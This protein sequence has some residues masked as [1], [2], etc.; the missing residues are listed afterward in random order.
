MKKTLGMIKAVNKFLFSPQVSWLSC[1][2]FLVATNFAHNGHW[3]AWGITILIGFGAFP[4]LWEYLKED[5][6][7]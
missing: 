5:Y 6:E 1:W 3:V 4:L 2:A 7:A